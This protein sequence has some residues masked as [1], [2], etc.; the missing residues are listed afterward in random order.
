MQSRQAGT[1]SATSRTAAAVAGA[2]LLLTLGALLGVWVAAAHPHNVL[3]GLTD[4]VKPA[5]AAKIP[6]AGH[7]ADPSSPGGATVTVTAPATTVTTGGSRTVTVSAPASTV[8]ETSTVTV[9]TGGTTA[10]TATP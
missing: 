5:K 7:T 9:T 6:A 10:T 3:Q 2:L 1:W 8:T 4:P